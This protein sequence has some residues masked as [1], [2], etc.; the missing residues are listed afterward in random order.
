MPLPI[1]EHSETLSNHVI[2]QV[3]SEINPSVTTTTVNIDMPRRTV[4]PPSNL[5]EYHCSLFINSP[6]LPLQIKPH[7]TLYHLF[8]PTQN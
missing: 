6:Y 3:V 7:H 1:P 4:E 5:S 8:L 2:L